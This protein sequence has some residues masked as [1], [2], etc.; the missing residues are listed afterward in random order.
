LT[1]PQNIG[2][3]SSVTFAGI[4]DSALTPNTI[5]LAGAAG[6]LTSAG[7]LNT[8]AFLIGSTSNPPAPGYIVGNG[9]NQITVGYTSPNVTLTLPQNIGTTSN[10]E[11]ASVTDT[12]LTQ[13][14]PVIG[15]FQGLL[16]STTVL[17]SGQVLSGV[18]GGAPVPTSIIG[19]T[20]EI[21]VTLE[22][23]SITIGLDGLSA[24]TFQ[25]IDLEYYNTPVAQI[26]TFDFNITSSATA[27]TPSFTTTNGTVYILETKAVFQCDSDPTIYTGYSKGWLVRISNVGVMTVAGFLYDEY[28]NVGSGVATAA[29]GYSS[30]SLY[31]TYTSTTATLCTLTGYNTV[32]IGH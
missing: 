30:N 4:T 16:T 22:D 13:Y 3:G 17:G 1:L 25:G 14:A 5:T 12:S 15:G 6:I 7:L 23:G 9:A 32:T 26:Y 31:A 10:V 19:T 18:N 27:N 21:I 28:Y 20:G 29:P 2:T 24:P 11:F 8:G